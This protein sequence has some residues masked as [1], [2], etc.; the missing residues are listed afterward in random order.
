MIGTGTVFGPYR[1]IDKIGAG[2]MGDVYRALDT[3]LERE[4]ALKLISDGFLVSE[5]HASPA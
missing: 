1:V 2:G 5:P 4:V 3:R